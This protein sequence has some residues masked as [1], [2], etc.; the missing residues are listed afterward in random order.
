M[1]FQV[2]RGFAQ[3]YISQYELPTSGG[4][5][6]LTFNTGML[7]DTDSGNDPPVLRTIGET[8]DD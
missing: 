5:S 1:A 8:F 4:V 3:F 6:A 7:M 2:G